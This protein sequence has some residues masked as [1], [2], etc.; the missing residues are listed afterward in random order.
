V[1]VRAAD[2]ADVAAVVDLWH[3]MRLEAGLGDELLVDGWRPRLE[4]FLGE[5]VASGRG[6]VWLAEADGTVVGTALGLL[7]EDYPFFLF[8]PGFYGF[9]GCVYTVPGWRRKG[10]ATDLVGRAVAWLRERG[11][12]GVRLL[13]TEASRGIYMGMGFHPV[14]DLEWEQG[15]P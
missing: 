6:V 14:E 4:T 2:A 7:K 12:S 5:V 15:R 3:A 11:A 13:P 8:R 9:V 10:V 1:T